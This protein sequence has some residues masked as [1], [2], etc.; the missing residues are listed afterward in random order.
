MT[1]TVGINYYPGRRVHLCY[2]ADA[3][4]VLLS[5]E[6]GCFRL[7]LIQGGAG[8]IRVNGTAAPLL[9]PALLCLNA[10][11]QATL[12]H[13][14][15]ISAQAVSFHPDLISDRLTDENVH[16]PA[17][18]SVTDRQ[19]SYLLLPFVQHDQ[20]RAGYLSIGPA[21]ARRIG[22]LMG[23]IGR[24]LGGQADWYWPCRSRTFFLELLFVVQRVFSAPSAAEPGLLGVPTDDTAGVLAY[25]HTNVHRQVTVAELCREFHLNR[26]TLQ[27]RFR[28]ITG[29]TL[30]AYL[31][32]LR[33]RLAANRLAE[34]T[35]TIEEIA[36]S[37]GFSDGSHLHRAFHK[38]MGCTPTEYRQR[39]GNAEP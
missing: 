20:A 1:E 9:A 7:V 32:N 15:G 36:V 30:R 6:A 24:E 39:M 22:D 19:D 29:H 11:E 14:A 33:V 35:E 8:M 12:E 34:T 17:G 18:L 37:V 23:S 4:P 26:T 3:A 38:A 5:G 31:I 10:S 16:E 27:G 21:T 28:A 2:H 25:L 13:E